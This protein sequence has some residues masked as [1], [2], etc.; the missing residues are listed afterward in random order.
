MIPGVVTVDTTAVFLVWSREDAVSLMTASGDA[1]S[2]FKEHCTVQKD[3][4]SRSLH[5][6]GPNSKA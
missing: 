1:H 2:D 5:V 4:K 3:G 6:L